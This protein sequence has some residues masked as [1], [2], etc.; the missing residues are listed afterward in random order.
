MNKEKEYII[1]SDQ[2]EHLSELCQITFSTKVLLIS[3]AHNYEKAFLQYQ[4]ILLNKGMS[5]QKIS[6][7]EGL[8][9]TFR[10]KIAGGKIDE[11]FCRETINQTESAHM[12]VKRAEDLLHKKSEKSLK[13]ASPAKT[14]TNFSPPKIKSAAK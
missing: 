1:L 11:D 10:T 14:T 7:S 5:L 6:F 3:D 12:R 9:K 13:A 2:G 8:K 4:D